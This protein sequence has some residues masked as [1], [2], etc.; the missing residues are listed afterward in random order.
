[1]A[2]ERESPFG[3]PVSVPCRGTEEKGPL[4]P[5]P[6]TPR[7]EAEGTGKAVS[8]ELGPKVGH[9]MSSSPVCAPARA[10]GPASAGWS[11]EEGSGAAAINSGRGEVK[12]LSGGC[13]AEGGERLKG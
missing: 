13:A 12:W 1:M 5:F 2:D 6:K 9:I 7:H 8:P 4:S 3:D 10:A 11:V